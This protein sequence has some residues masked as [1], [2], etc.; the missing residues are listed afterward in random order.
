MVYNGA[1]TKH[2]NHK[3]ICTLGR[4]KE[5]PSSSTTDLLD[6]LRQII[7]DHQTTKTNAVNEVCVNGSFNPYSYFKP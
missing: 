6:K 3:V 4:S 5:S 1:H 2:H 7:L